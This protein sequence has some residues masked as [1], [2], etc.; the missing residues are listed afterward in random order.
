MGMGEEAFGLVE[1]RAQQLPGL[2]LVCGVV[3]RDR[4]LVEEFVE[5]APTPA[6]GGGVAFDR[7]LP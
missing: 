3:L 2:P 1:Q 6:P 7:E 4:A 5:C